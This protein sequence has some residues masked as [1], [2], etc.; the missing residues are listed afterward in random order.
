MKF[1]DSQK[2]DR[3]FTLERLQHFTQSYS[4]SVHI[5]MPNAILFLFP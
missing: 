2:G 1:T 4:N 3:I 5:L